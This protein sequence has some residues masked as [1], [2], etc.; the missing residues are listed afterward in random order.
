MVTCVLRMG[1]T[2]Q[3]ATPC[4]RTT[5]SS[6]T[7]RVRVRPKNSRHASECPRGGGRGER[8]GE[9]G[10]LS[11][12]THGVL[13]GNSQGGAALLAIEGFNSNGANFLSMVV[14]GLSVAHSIS[15]FIPDLP[16]YLL[17]YMA[18]LQ[19]KHPAIRWLGG[20]TAHG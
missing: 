10:G 2:G 20:S 6:G 19:P 16:T 1:A 13:P 18:W 3:A 15:A 14:A 11:S 12:V 8:G 17:R 7:G 5:S 4:G 9:G